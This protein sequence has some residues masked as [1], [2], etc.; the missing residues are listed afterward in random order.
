MNN[1][2]AGLN[3]MY[4]LSYLTQALKS[5]TAVYAKQTAEGKQEIIH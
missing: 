5:I 3:C 2:F 1:L 4:W